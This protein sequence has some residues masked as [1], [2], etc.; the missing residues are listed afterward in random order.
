MSLPINFR[1]NQN[2]N[3]TI[4]VHE[5]CLVEH[6]IGSMLHNGYQLINNTV[7]WRKKWLWFGKTQYIC[8]FRLC[9]SDSVLQRWIS[10][11]IQSENY[12][13][14]REYQNILNQRR[15]V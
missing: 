6:A 15:K 3:V 9:P 12:E 5:S 13:W 4:I 1:L 2:S 14:A 11:A 8:H 10:E 7:H